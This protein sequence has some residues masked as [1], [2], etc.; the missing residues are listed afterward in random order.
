L[1]S[2]R[3]THRP[4]RLTTVILIP[5]P[6]RR[7]RTTCIYPTRARSVLIDRNHLV[8]CG[9][10][11]Q[12]LLTPGRGGLSF[13]RI[14]DIPFEACVIALESWR[15]HGHDG[16]LQVGKSWLR[17]PIEHDRGSGTCRV[18]IDMAHGPLRPLLRM[19]LDVD[20]WSSPSR[21]ALE[22]IPCRR[23][24]ATTR[25]FRAGHLL[26]DSLTLALELEQQIQALELLAGEERKPVPPQPRA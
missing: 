21:T 5:W 17:G 14:V 12:P 13:R 25:Y 9:K 18:K 6:A 26:L 19:R 16:E 8:M 23:V 15:L 4:D 11:A 1:L 24:R 22:L 10:E 7:D 2:A 20:R 3:N